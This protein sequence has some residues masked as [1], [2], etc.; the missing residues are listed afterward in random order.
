MSGRR[1][2]PGHT[3]APCGA[4]N[5]ERQHASGEQRPKDAPCWGCQR[6][7]RRADQI[8][9]LHRQASADQRLQTEPRSPRVRRFNVETLLGWRSG[10]EA[11]LQAALTQLGEATGLDAQHPDVQAEHLVPYRH[12][13]ERHDRGRTFARSLLYSPKQIAAFET[14]VLAIEQA[15]ADAY[16]AGHAA[17]ADLL[18]RLARGDTTLFDLGVEQER[19]QNERAK[20]VNTPE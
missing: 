4:C 3:F 20:R 8:I 14:I 1:A 17:G 12:V 7:L 9:D 11:E 19:V 2:K 15:I 16:A 10:I 18:G 13:H 5:G 6:L